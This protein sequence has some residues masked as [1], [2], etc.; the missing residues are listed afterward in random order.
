MARKTGVS[1]STYERMIFG[2][3]AISI[4]DVA[5]GATKGGNTLE[6]TRVFRDTRPDGALGPVKDY[7]RLESSDAWLTVRL[8]ELTEENVYYDLAGAAL[9][10]HV[11]RGG[12]ISAGVYIP[13]V[14]LD[15]E[16][17]GVTATTENSEVEVE[18]INCLV[19]GPFTLA[20]PEDGEV[21]VEMKFHAH[22][23]ASALT[24][25]PWTITFTAK[26]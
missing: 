20:L 24:T 10:N 22:F 11:I 1:T 14:Q 13:S 7:R 15:A 19:E 12:D 3:G 23:N 17:S 16:M 8:M 18:L 25:E 5:I 6:I 26:A 21:V 4:N 9:S 2:P